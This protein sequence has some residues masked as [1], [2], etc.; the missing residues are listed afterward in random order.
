MRRLL[1]LGARVGG[2]WKV[3]GGPGDPE[4][5]QFGAN[6][7]KNINNKTISTFKSVL[8]KMVARFGLVGKQSPWPYSGAI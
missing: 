8:P 5:Q 1:W 2:V 3:P 6:N 7:T 4:I